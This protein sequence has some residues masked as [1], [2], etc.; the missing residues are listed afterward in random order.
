MIKH[1]CS[2]S[3]MGRGA[4]QSP[5]GSHQCPLARI[6]SRPYLH[7]RQ[8]EVATRH[9]RA[10]GTERGYGPPGVTMARMGT[11]LNPDPNAVEPQLF[12]YVVVPGMEYFETFSEGL[13]LIHNPWARN[14]LPVG[15]VRD[16][17]EHRRLEDG[18]VEIT[19]SQLDPFMSQ[20]NIFIGPGATDVA[21]TV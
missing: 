7:G 14:P 17:T 1:D 5:S 18:R 10:L 16:V 11:V 3:V 13:H 19:A 8:H 21:L 12:G 20:T 2:R 15:A 4:A 6:S 9:Q